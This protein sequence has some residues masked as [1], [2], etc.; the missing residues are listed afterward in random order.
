M[1]LVAVLLLL[2]LRSDDVLAFLV[3]QAAES[4]LLMLLLTTH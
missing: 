4:R 2:Y 3:G 1:L